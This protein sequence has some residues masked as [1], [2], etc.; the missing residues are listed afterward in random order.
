[1]IIGVFKKWEWYHKY[2]AEFYYTY[3][4][5]NGLIYYVLLGHENKLLNGRCNMLIEDVYLMMVW[6]MTLSVYIQLDS[7]FS[8]NE[9]KYKLGES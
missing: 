6:T 1:M 5:G 3:S 8:V 7:D 9:P 2:L 4:L